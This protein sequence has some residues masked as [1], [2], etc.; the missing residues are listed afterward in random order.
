MTPKPEPAAP[1][2]ELSKGDVVEHT[3]FGEGMVVSILKMNG[4]ALLEVAFDQV[5]TKRL[6]L[7][8]ASAH[9]KKK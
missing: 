7:K 8:T 9:M 2:L 6:M 5:G 4:D 1:M 3:A